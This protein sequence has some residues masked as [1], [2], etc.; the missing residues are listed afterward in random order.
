MPRK[1]VL[2]RHRDDPLDDRVVT[3]AC[4]NGFEPVLIKPF[5]GEKILEIG[6]DVAGSVIYGGGFVAT[7]TQQHPFLL[8]EYR[9]IDDCMRADIPLLGICQGAQQIAHHLGAWV[10]PR[11][12]KGHEFGYYPIRPTAEG[13]GFLERPLHVAQAHYHTFDLPAGAVRLASGNTYENQAF[14]YGEKTYAVQFH[15]EVTIEGFRRWQTSL[16][17]YYEQTGSQQRGEQDRLMHEHDAAQA[18][19]FYGFL[20]RFFGKG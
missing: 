7:E 20:C 2:I 16:S 8:D 3:F 15:P 10:G 19:W 4:R 11:E 17:A 18:E 9:W 6:D 13:T 12:G 5:A 14:R 1:I